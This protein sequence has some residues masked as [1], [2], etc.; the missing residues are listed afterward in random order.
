M[1]RTTS[2]VTALFLSLLMLLSLGTV[3]FAAD[4]PAEAELPNPYV[5]KDNDRVLSFDTA[6]GVLTISGDGNQIT[7]EAKFWDYINAIS[8]TCKTVYLT[9]NALMRNRDAKGSEFYLFEKAL[10]ALTSLEEFKVEE[11]SSNYA[12]RNGVLYD[13]TVTSLIH[14]PAGKKDDSY[15]MESR[16]MSIRSFAFCNTQYL[17]ILEFNYTHILLP[18]PSVLA[19]RVSDGSRRHF[20][21]IDSYGLGNVDLK[22]E[23][24]KE[25]S[26]RT[27]VWYGEEQEL[28]EI[29]AKHRGNNIGR[30][31]NISTK[32]TSIIND[33]SVFSNRM[34]FVLGLSKENRNNT[35]ND[36]W[37]QLVEAVSDIAN[38]VTWE[39]LTTLIG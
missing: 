14:Y 35:K 9:K 8:G 23:V 31:A 38:T 28:R 26:I 33:F 39:T 25:S 13:S 6:T 32:A 27:L 15:K 19:N 17:R 2:R 29:A 37:T 34:L 36:L 22:T 12:A 30:D 24:E 16:C 21:S 4:E 10:C 5:F 7:D 18:M 1:N 11:G 20:M 3:A